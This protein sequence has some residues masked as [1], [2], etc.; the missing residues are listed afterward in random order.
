MSWAFP[1]G[2]RY[3][4]PAQPCL[5]PPPPQV[6]VLIDTLYHQ[7]TSTEPE[8]DLKKLSQVRRW[9]QCRDTAPSTAACQG[10]GACRHRW[11]HLACPSGTAD[12]RQTHGWLLCV[13]QVCLLGAGAMIGDMSLKASAHGAKRSAT[14]VALTD[15]VA[16]KVPLAEFKRRMPEEVLEVRPACA[17]GW[18]MCPPPVPKR[19]MLEEVLEVRPACA[20]GWG[21]CPPPVPRLGAVQGT[22]SR[23]TAATVAASGW[24]SWVHMLFPG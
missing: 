14:V 1:H 23:A 8:H 2:S 4:F 15:T 13:V 24:G 19:R 20:F 9:Q 11:Q 17:C 18:G 12:G 22:S 21:V 7:G 5:T 6:C 3:R 10:A 16:Y